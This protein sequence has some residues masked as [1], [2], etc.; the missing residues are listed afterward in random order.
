M[1]FQE[2]ITCAYVIELEFFPTPSEAFMSLLARGSMIM[3]LGRVSVSRDL[4]SGH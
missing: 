4:D 3:D 1:F 2:T